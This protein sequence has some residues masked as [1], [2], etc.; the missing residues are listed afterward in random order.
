[1]GASGG[2]SYVSGTSATARPIST[3][4]QPD[5]HVR[6]E[7]HLHRQADRHVRG[8]R[9]GLEDGAGRPSART[10]PRP[11]PSPRSTVPPRREVHRDG[12]GHRCARATARRDRRRVD[13]ASHRRQRV[14]PRPTTAATPSRSRPSS[15]STAT[16]THTVEYRARDAQATSDPSGRSRSRSTSPAGGGLAA[17]RSRTSS[18]APPWIPSGPSRVRPAAARPLING[19]LELPML[20]GDFIANDAL[21]SNTVLEDAP[22]GEWTATTQ[23]DTA[24]IDANGEQAGLCCG[25]RRTRTR[26]RRSWRSTRATASSS[27]STSSRRAGGQPADLVEHHAR[28]GRHAAAARAGARPQHGHGHHRRVLDRQRRQL[29]ARRQRGPTPRR[30][31]VRSRSAPWPSVVATVAARHRSTSAAPRR[32]DRRPPR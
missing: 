8:R 22:S 31:P 26:S 10:T 21:A 28:P 25:S 4:R 18:T 11:P 32:L 29:G 24:G 23:I 20:Q 3:E 1:M 16:A 17:C 19:R 9:E 5:A 13:R 2:V 6:R 30:S 27:S 7:R 14:A 15:T 12:G